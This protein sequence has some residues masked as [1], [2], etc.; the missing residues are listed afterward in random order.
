MKRLAVL[1]LACVGMQ[2]GAASRDLYFVTQLFPPFITQDSSGKPDGAL[3]V[4][5]QRA[6]ARLGWNCNVQIMVWKRAL[7]TISQGGADGLVLA[8]DAPE[9]RAVMELTKPV[10]TS[11]YGLYALSG[12][13]LRYRQPSDLARR[14]VAVYGPSLSQTNC[15]K[16]VAGVAG[17]NMTVELDPETVLRKLSAGRYGAEAVAFSNDDVARYWIRQDTLSNVRQLA[18]VKQLA[19]LYGFTRSRLKPGMVEEFNRA[20]DEMCKDGELSRLASSYGMRLASCR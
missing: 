15:E 10:L 16:L 20:L 18:E 6:C 19:Y 4:I 3:V 8:Q 7:L 14:N 9:R 1:L 17:V 11:S 13:G 12:N 5:L 2:A